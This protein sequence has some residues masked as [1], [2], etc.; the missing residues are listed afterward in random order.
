MVLFLFIIMRLELKRVNVT[1]RLS[2]LFA[3]R[4][5]ILLCLIFQ[6]LFFVSTQFFDLGG[7]MPT[8]NSSFSHFIEANQYID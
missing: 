2:D 5:L 8:E 7:F 1:T 4:H 3:F 6:I